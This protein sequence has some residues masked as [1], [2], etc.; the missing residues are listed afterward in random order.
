MKF[1]AVLTN[2]SSKLFL[3]RERKYK[4]ETYTMLRLCLI[5]FLSARILQEEK[6]LLTTKE[7][8]GMGEDPCDYC[9]LHYALSE[10]VSLVYIF[11]RKKM[12]T[13]RGWKR[14]FAR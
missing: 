13:F 5:K 8:N 2:G 4:H 11:L 14:E 12:K 1:K 3:G 10:I 9:K 7:E 6:A